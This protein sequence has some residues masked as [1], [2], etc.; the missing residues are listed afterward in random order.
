MNFNLRGRG[1]LKKKDWQLRR[2]Q[3]QNAQGPA[4]TLMFKSMCQGHEAC[5]PGVQLFKLSLLKLDCGPFCKHLRSDVLD[6]DKMVS[7]VVLLCRMV[8]AL[9]GAY[10]VEQPCGSLM[11]AHPDFQDL[12]KEGGVYKEWISME[13]LGGVPPSQC[14]SQA[15]VS[16]SSCTVLFENIVALFLRPSASIRESSSY[17]DAICASGKLQL[18]LCI[19]IACHMA[20]HAPRSYEKKLLGSTATDPILLPSP[21]MRHLENLAALRPHANQAQAGP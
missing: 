1:I 20:L 17:H 15:K 8:D 13:T 2:V 21:L 19:Q 10:V 18:K 5:V 11:E 9:Q 3:A 14:P 7:R 4:K 6:A 16:S 12:I